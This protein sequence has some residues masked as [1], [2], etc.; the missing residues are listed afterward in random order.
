[1]FAIKFT[2]QKSYRKYIDNTNTKYSHIQDGGTMGARRRGQEGALAPPGNS[3]TW[4]AP[5][6][7]L[8]RKKFKKYFF[9]N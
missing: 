5:K 8:T 6:D 4:G 3:K 9:L 7:I 1:M 2:S